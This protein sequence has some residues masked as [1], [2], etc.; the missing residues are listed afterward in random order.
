MEKK[1]NIKMIKHTHSLQINHSD[2]KNKQ[3]QDQVSRL[4]EVGKLKKKHRF[5]ISFISIFFCTFWHFNINND[6]ST[7]FSL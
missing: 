6:F 4:L 1:N 5:W 7:R 2:L 3:P